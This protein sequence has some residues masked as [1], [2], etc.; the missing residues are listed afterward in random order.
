MRSS[1]NPFLPAA[2]AA[3]VLSGSVAAVC[4]IRGPQV[5]WWASVATGV[6]LALVLW[7]MVW[8]GEVA[9]GTV[10]SAVVTPRD[11]AM[12][13]GATLVL[14][15]IGAAVTGWLAAWSIAAV[16]AGAVMPAGR[17]AVR[18]GAGTDDES[19]VAGG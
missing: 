17:A 7:V 19:A 15:G 3:L 4:A 16:V 5:P 14:G 1:M 2:L 9:R 12:A 8:A 11:Y 18:G 10:R 6:V 13:V